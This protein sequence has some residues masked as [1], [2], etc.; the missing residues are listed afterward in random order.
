[1]F[2]GLIQDTGKVIYLKRNAGG[3][4]LAI[5]TSLKQIEEGESIAVNGVCQTVT[6]LR[7]GIF[8]CDILSE[9]LRVTNLGFLSS[10]KLVNLERALSVGEKLGGHIVNGHVDGIGVITRVLENPQ[11]L[12][13][14][15]DRDV[16]KYIVSKGSVAVDGISLTVGP[17]PEVDRFKVFI[18]PHTW[19]NTNLTAVSPG[20][21]VNI[22]V[23]ILAKYMEKF[24]SG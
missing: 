17:E 2:T 24:V 9:T 20:Y 18:I 21:K 16:S 8:T 1:M 14:S 7:R 11:G 12:E 23:D 19:E 10:G 15:T 22:E 6:E 13:I 3:A 4:R 5:K